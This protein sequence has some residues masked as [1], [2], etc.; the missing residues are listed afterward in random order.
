M[1]YD[2]QH[3]HRRSIRLR[4]YD[5]A[6]AGV[7]F[8]TICTHARQHL[9][10]DPQ[11]RQIAEEQWVALGHAG[12]RGIGGGRVTVDAFVVMPDHVHG[13]IIIHDRGGDVPTD[14][15]RVGAQQQ[16]DDFPISPT[17]PAAAAPLRN[18]RPPS[19]PRPPF[20][21]CP[22]FDP[23]PPSDV[24]HGL[25]INVAPGS[26]GAI[27]RSYKATVARRV[28]VHRRRRG[29]A[30]WQR[31]YYERIVRDARELAAVR[32]YIANNPRRWVARRE[33]LDALLAEMCS[34]TT[35]I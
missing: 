16:P 18:T 13:I 26:L 20:D 3:H 4:G 7:Y 25:G 15:V 9:F 27:V 30:L 31:G 11:L 35:R 33:N 1:P 32:R 21:T 24:T 5:Y 12:A 14:G 28:N 29:S 34:H 17:H 22:P 10:S 8:V 2:P 23:R 6:Q 19:D